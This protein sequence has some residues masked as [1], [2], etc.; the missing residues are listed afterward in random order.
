M[1]LLGRPRTVGADRRSPRSAPTLNVEVVAVA[2]KDVLGRSGEDLAVA[3]LEA[4]GF[5]VLDRNWRCREGEI[6]VVA[7]D[8]AQLVVCEVKTRTGVGFGTP[9]DAVTPVKLTRLRRLALRW[10]EQRGLPWVRDIRV[11][12]IGIVQPRGGDP[13]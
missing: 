10:R 9:L 7:R 6:D 3:H 8:G 1:R 11:D 5:D 2:A 4:D 12:V 13:V